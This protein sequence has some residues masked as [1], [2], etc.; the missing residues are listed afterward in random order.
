[1][2]QS[3]NSWQLVIRLGL[4]VVLLH[5]CLVQPAAAYSVLTHEEVVDL[6]WKDNF[7]PLLKKRFPAATDDELKK[8]HAFAYG[9]SLIQDMGYYPFGNK[10]FSDHTHYVRTG[11]FI[12]NLI[13]EAS[14]LNEYAFA[15]GALAHYSADNTGHP[16]VN[17]AVGIEFPKL[18]KKFGDVVTYEDDPKAHIRIEF[19]FDVTQV[20]KNRYTSDRYHDFIG[21]EIAKPVLERAFQDTYNL[22]LSDVI[23]KEDLAF[24]TFRRAISQVIPEM[25]RVALLTRRAEIVKETPNFRARQFRYYLSRTSYQREWGKGYRRPGWRTRLLAFILRFMPKIGPFRALDFKVPSHRTE[26]LYIASVDLTIENYKKLLTES[27]SGKLHLTNTDFD[28]GHD[29]HAGEYALTDKTYEHLLDQLAAHNFDKITAELRNNI[30]AF[31][32]DPAAFIHT[33]KNA[34]AWEKT[35]AEL[36]KLRAL[37]EPPPLEPKLTSDM[38]LEIDG[39]AEQMMSDEGGLD[40][41][42]IAPSTD[43]AVSP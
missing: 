6:V 19:G 7:L 43:T 1:M 35:Q 29:T 32:S 36:A 42:S 33:K 31:Y 9:G 28:T 15:L 5:S 38:E 21:F 13:N 11:D 16:T 34:K 14:D 37:P 30:L 27:S 40:Q 3:I 2:R 20:A 17:K 41:T 8:A 24:G 10:Y 39:I 26:D 22:P 18:R 25:T 23:T 4:A 12:V